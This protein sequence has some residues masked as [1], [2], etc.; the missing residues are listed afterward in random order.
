MDRSTGDIS[1]YNAIGIPGNAD[2]S[3]SDN[4][5]LCIGGGVSQDCPSG[6]V[7]LPCP[8]RWWVDYVPEGAPDPLAG[9]GSSVEQPVRRYLC[10]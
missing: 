3:G 1:Q 7:Y 8:Q 6:P 2:L 10:E 4:N 9:A 5:V